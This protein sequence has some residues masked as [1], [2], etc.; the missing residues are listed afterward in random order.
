MPLI[1]YVS[2][3]GEVPNVQL[4]K[5]WTRCAVDSCTIL[6]K[7]GEQISRLVPPRTGTWDRPRQASRRSIADIMYVLM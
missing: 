5:R 2:A 7:N 4:R 1:L 3:M 6:F